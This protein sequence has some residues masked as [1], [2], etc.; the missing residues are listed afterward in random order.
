[1]SICT[2]SQ[3][4][5]IVG[6]DLA[7]A[8]YAQLEQ[9]LQGRSK[10]GPQHSDQDETLSVLLLLWT[11]PSAGILQRALASPTIYPLLASLTLQCDRGGVLGFSSDI[12]LCAAQFPLQNILRGALRENNNT[13][14][15]DKLQLTLPSSLR[16]KYLVAVL[17]HHGR[18]AAAAELC[19]RAAARPV[20]MYTAEAGLAH[21]V[22]SLQ[23]W[24]PEGGIYSTGLEIV[25]IACK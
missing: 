9:T 8:A 23:N 3:A 18:I 13:V 15:P 10:N 12:H 4:S 1:L 25:L 14:K 21:L 7:D 22:Y 5:F 6:G 16:S 24:T 20:R 11:S 2:F 17:V 19:W